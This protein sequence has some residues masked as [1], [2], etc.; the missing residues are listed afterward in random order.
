MD[1]KA[2]Y[3]FTLQELQEKALE[4][5]RSHAEE[6]RGLVPRYQSLLSRKRWLKKNM[7]G[8]R[9]MPLK[10]LNKSVL[11]DFVQIPFFDLESEDKAIDYIRK[12]EY[13]E[14]GYLVATIC[15]AL[16]SYAYKTIKSR[17]SDYE[18]QIKYWKRSSYFGYDP[19]YPTSSNRTVPRGSGKH[20]SGLDD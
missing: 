17:I 7:R 4:T 18:Y 2:R 16:E 8:Y 14:L 5:W 9:G 20:S 6:Y 13:S 11:D 3:G 1:G 15:R 19:T 10:R 12:L